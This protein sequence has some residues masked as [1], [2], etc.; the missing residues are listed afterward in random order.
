MEKEIKM[1]E[2]EIREIDK[3]EKSDVESDIITFSYDCSSYL[4][5]ICC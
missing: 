2:D 3:F 1:I 5:I 4:T